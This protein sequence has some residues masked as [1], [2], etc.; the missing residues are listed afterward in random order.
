MET[1]PLS[2]PLSTTSV[3]E[4]KG[5]S[6]GKLA[7]QRFLR[8][9]I[10]MVSAIFIILLILV[11]IFAPYVAPK[12]Y[13]EEDFFASYEMPGE[14]FLLGS[15]FL[16]RDF[17]S[18]II[19]GTRISLT[20]GVIGALTAFMIG[21]LYGITSGY[22]GGK[23][24]EWMMRIVDILFAIPTLIVVI[25]IMVYFKAGRPEDFV[26][27]K[28][29]FYDLDSTMGGILF[30]FI[31]IGV[32]SW[33]GMA[34]L[35]RGEALSLRQREFVE[36]AV[37]QGLSHRH[38]LFKH[39]LPNVIG[40]CIIAE[41]MAI[42]SYILTEAFLS[43]IGLGVNP[44]NSKLGRDDLRRVARV[45]FVPAWG[46]LSDT[47]HDVNCSCLQFLREMVCAMPWIPN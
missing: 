47:S 22:I 7:L 8:N 39:I 17:L 40:P 44:P 3:I 42:P 34:R 19:Y 21:L 35:A 14:N 16:G 37:S 27:F 2:V 18:R 33:L 31:G 4:E 13:A 29:F 5:E 6:L 15:D 32:T 25:L 26:G 28:R 38:I 43:F 10:A 45:T 41:T 46:H 36:S 11:A 9:K 1:D 30:V 24:D 23:V 20:V 12:H